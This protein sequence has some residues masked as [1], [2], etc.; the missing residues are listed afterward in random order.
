MS[1]VIVGLGNPGDEYTNTR[2]NTGRLALE[3]L[4]KKL[5]LGAWKED[6][7]ANALTNGAKIGKNIAV[8]A[9]PNTF[10]NKSGL[11]VARYVKSIKAAE[12]LVVVYDDLDLP[13]GSIKLSFDRGSGGHKGIESIIKSVKT[14]KF[15]RIRIGVS[16]ATPKG[17]VKKVAGDD[18]VIDF[19]LGKFKPAEL[20]VLKKVFKRVGEAVEC[21]VA[22][23]R[24]RAMNQFN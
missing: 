9:L 20:D 8:F 12:K 10:M 5:G 16:R 3:A 24:E 21:V 11:A 23:G 18:E 19:I 1:W 13:I 17:V 14:R 15:V 22:E 2:H 4:A 7:K 6:K